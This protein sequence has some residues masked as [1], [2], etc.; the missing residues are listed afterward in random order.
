MKTRHLG[1]DYELQILDQLGEPLLEVADARGG[2]TFALS[3]PGATFTVAAG[4][5]SKVPFRV[6]L[7]VDEDGVGYAYPIY[8]PERFTTSR[9]DGWWASHGRKHP[10]L[11]VTAAQAAAAAADDDLDPGADS[12]LDDGGAVAARPLPPPR[13]V[14]SGGGANDDETAGAGDGW[15]SKVTVSFKR[16]HVLPCPAPGYEL[17]GD[18]PLCDKHKQWISGAKQPALPPHAPP[19]PASGGGKTARRGS[20]LRRSSSSPTADSPSFGGSESPSLTPAIGGTSSSIGGGAGGSSDNCASPGGS[21]GSGGGGGPGGSTRFGG[22]GGRGMH[23]K[24]VPDVEPVSLEMFFETAERL[25]ALGILNPRRAE[26]APLYASLG[27]VGPDTVG[28]IAV[29]P[30]PHA[31]RGSG[32]SGVG[33]ESME[34]L[35]EDGGGGGD[36][37]PDGAGKVQRQGSLT[38]AMRRGLRKLVLKGG[39]P[40]RVRPR[41]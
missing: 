38:S 29:A 14:S 20:L 11:L 3:A 2:A 40:T 4:T 18:C 36:G 17:T 16:I 26:H 13:L 6:S 39:G 24:V 35:S 28:P 12:P 27:P 33:G 9:F 1:I 37:S 19:S 23:W 5:N 25:Q 34:P 7:R 30:G 21:S 32:G 10:F 15:S 22:L 31:L 41:S 8:A